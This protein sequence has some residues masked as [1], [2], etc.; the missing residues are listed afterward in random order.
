VTHGPIIGGSV[1][2]IVVLGIWAAIIF[3]G[4][5][6]YDTVKYREREDA[7]RYTCVTST[8]TLPH[9]RVGYNV[10]GSWLLKLDDGRDIHGSGPITCTEEAR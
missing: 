3:F 2:P 10:R 5:A 8:Q 4:W 7:R 6:V 1:P 9:V